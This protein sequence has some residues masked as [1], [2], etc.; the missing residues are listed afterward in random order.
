[1]STQ[2]ETIV[3][4]L[5]NNPGYKGVPVTEDGRPITNPTWEYYAREEKLHG[6]LSQQFPTTANPAPLGL[7]GFALTTFVLSM[8]NAGGLRSI[9]SPSNGVVMGLA[10]FYG[11]LCQLLAGMWEF[12][13]GNTFGALAFSSYGGFWMSFAALSINAFGFLSGYGSTHEGQVALHNDLGIYLLAWGMF[14]LWMTI[15]AHRTTVALFTLFFLVF[16]TFLMLAIHQF[17][18]M[19]NEEYSLLC[20]EA[21][22]C[23]GVMAAI[24]AWYC[25]YAALLTNKNSFFTLPVGELDPIYRSWGWLPPLEANNK[26]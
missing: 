24:L 4:D 3:V 5:E 10:L 15:A 9:H 13:T 7:C 11:G 17:I 12:K 2:Q 19:W 14:S 23:F 22:G 6:F 25:A 16:L 20:Q 18:W 1:M 26:K 8:M 21:G